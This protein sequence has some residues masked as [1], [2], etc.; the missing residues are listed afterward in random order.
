MTSAAILTRQLI[1]EN[2]T[3][4]EERAWLTWLAE[5]PADTAA[6]QEFT[7]NQKTLSDEARQL[8]ERGVDPGAQAMQD[9]LRALSERC[10]GPVRCG[11]GIH[12]AGTPGPREW[13]RLEILQLRNRRCGRTPL[14]DR[15]A[16]GAQTAGLLLEVP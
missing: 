9:V 15:D 5:H 11:V 3:P 10:R 1:N 2:I 4:E 13:I 6:I 12:R 8:M 7:K 14:L 16:L